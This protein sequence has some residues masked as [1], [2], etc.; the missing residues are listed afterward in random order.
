MGTK[1][2]PG[3]YDCY[4]NAEPDEPMFIL[5]GRDPFAADLVD[6]WANIRES[7]RGPSAKVDE[8]RACA[9]A[10]REWAAR[11][12]PTDEKGGST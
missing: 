9:K 11:T 6:Y 7:K 5:L 12:A 4:A 2:K 1:N 8:A 10:M 3:T